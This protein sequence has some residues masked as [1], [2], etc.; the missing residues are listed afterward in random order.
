MRA[1]NFVNDTGPQAIL[2]DMSKVRRLLEEMI[3]NLENMGPL[4]VIN[5]EAVV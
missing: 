3:Y 2:S 5:S 4:F 1:V